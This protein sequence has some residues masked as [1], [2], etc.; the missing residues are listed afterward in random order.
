MDFSGAI[1]L[2]VIP[3]KHGDVF[4]EVDG[5]PSLVHVGINKPLYRI[6]HSRPILRESL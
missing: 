2:K 3:H 5:L 1:R 4:G 6:S